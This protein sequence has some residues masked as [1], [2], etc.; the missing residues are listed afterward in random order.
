MGCPGRRSVPC[1]PDPFGP[2]RLTVRTRIQGPHEGACPSLDPQDV[3]FSCPVRTPFQPQPYSSSYFG[4]SA[5]PLLGSTTSFPNSGSTTSFPNSFGSSLASV[6]GMARR[7]SPSTLA[8]YRPLCI[9]RSLGRVCWGFRRSCLLVRKFQYSKNVLP[10]LDWWLV[11]QGGGGAGTF[12]TRPGPKATK[13]SIFRCTRLFQ[14]K[15]PSFC[16]SLRCMPILCASASF[17][18]QSGR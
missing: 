1:G 10:H 16:L 2:S 5:S 14:T 8:T 15:H 17:E 7:S 11:E 4:R 18:A 9:S 6:W 12:W 3:P 13:R